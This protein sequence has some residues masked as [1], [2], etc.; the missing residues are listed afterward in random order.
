MDG[1]EEDGEPEDEVVE[2]S[3][4]DAQAAA[5]DAT[6]KVAAKNPSSGTAANR[7]HAIYQLKASTPSNVNSTPKATVSCCYD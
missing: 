1:I 7:R 6:P 2:L 4:A 3:A 5:A